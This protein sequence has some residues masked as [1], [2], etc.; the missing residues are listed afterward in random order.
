MSSSSPVITCQRISSLHTTHG[1]I[2]YI[3]TKAKCRHL[4]KLTYKGTFQQVFLRVYRLEML[5][6]VNCYSVAP[7]TFSLVQLPPPLPCVKKYTVYTYTVCNGRGGYGVLQT[8]AS[9]SLHRSIF[10]DD[11]ILHWPFMSL[12]F[13]IIQP[14]AKVRVRGVVTCQRESK[15]GIQD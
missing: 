10:L 14:S 4:R 7:L 11:D 3:D 1:L 15:K 2:K 13:L 9:K 6:F 8:P 12:I 5:V